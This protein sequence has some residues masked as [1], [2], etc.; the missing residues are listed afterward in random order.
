MLNSGKQLSTACCC[1]SAPPHETV[2]LTHVFLAGEISSF[3]EEGGGQSSLSQED[4]LLLSRLLLLLNPAYP[5]SYDGKTAASAAA[6]ANRSP[7]NGYSLT[8][9]TSRT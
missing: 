4:K 9:I 3:D 1:Y 5:S 8:E 2:S 7:L 6:T